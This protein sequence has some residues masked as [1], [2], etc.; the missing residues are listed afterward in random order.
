MRSI[1][2]QIKEERVI[3]IALNKGN[4]IVGRDVGVVLNVLITL[5]LLNIY[6]FVSMETVIRIIVRRI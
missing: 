5:I 3:L 1:V 2:C 6:Q 4:G